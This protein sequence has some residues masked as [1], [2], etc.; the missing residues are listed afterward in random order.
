M[1]SSLFSIV[2]Q[3]IAKLLVIFFQLF[4]INKNIQDTLSLRVARSGTKKP[5]TTYRCICLLRTGGFPVSFMSFV[6][7]SQ[8]NLSLHEFRNFLFRCFQIF[9]PRFL[10]PQL[11]AEAPE[12]EQLVLVQ[13]SPDVRDD[14]W[15][16]DASLYVDA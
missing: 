6:N 8:F 7:F 13:A 4:K 5:A 16:E 15:L 1:F 14:V 11:I 3:M 12:A 9:V 10:Q 2:F